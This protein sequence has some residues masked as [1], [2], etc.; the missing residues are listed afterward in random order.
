MEFYQI[1]HCQDNV[2]NREWK[3]SDK[4]E[5]EDKF[6]NIVVEMATEYSETLSEDDLDAIVEDGYYTVSNE[7]ISL[8][9]WDIEKL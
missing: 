8:T 1:I 5:A 7:G 3:F 4:T 6:L 2:L 9:S